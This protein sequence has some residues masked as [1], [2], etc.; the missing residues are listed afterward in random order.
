MN[1]QER[2]ALALERT[3]DTKA[4]V[5]GVGA[6]E[7]TAE[8]FKQLF[9]GKKAIIVADTNT[10]EAAGRKVSE[11]LSNGG[12]E[13]VEPFIFTDPDLDARMCFVDDL[14]EGLKKVDAIAVAV[15]SGVINDDTKYCSY[16]LGR[17]YMCVGTAASVD[18]FTA[19]GATI[20]FEGNKITYPC[21]A[22]AGFIMDPT[23][24]AA[25]PNFLVAS[26][27]ADLFAKVC[28]GIDWMLADAMGVEKIDPFV[29][30]LV[31][32]PL[33]DS[34]SDP[35]ALKE[36]D[37]EKTEALCEGLLMSGFSMQAYQT[38]RPAS[39]AEH[40]FAHCWEMENL[41]YGGHHVSHGFKVAIGTLSATATIQFL[42]G[43][44]IPSIDIEPLVAAWPSWEEMEERI[45]TT[46]EGKPSH[47]ERG[48][49]ETKGKY[50]T[51]EELRAQL[52]NLQKAWPAL[53]EQI[54]G[55]LI[56]F[57]EVRER[58]RLV[59]APYEPEHIGVTRERLK[60]TFSYIPYMRSRVSCFDVVYRLGLMDEL[61]DYVFGENGV[62]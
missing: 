48:F 47:M 13:Q 30:G 20:V 33:L 7:K 12:V 59:G 40:Q 11:V 24:A 2:I 29:W 4:L 55:K 35:A 5:L 25:A 21:P 10:W 52:E 15:G 37:V 46:F 49:K 58:L 8:M 16:H 32:D 17:Q 54:A 36:G 18:G 60:K 19:Y 62:F 42:L 43:K 14:M 45:K 61:I 26:G 57:E 44:D 31:Q 23:V 53:K 28:C 9:P 56:P 27:Y 51:K 41:C 38:S 22:P 6:M 1:R 3:T 50:C 39:G 34:L